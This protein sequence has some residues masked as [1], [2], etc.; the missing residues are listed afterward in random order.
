MSNRATL[1]E[2]TRNG[3]F[4]DLLNGVFAT[5]S[6]LPSEQELARR[7]DVSRLTIREAVG[8]LVEAGYVSRRQGDGTYVSGSL[9]RR[10]ALDTT[11]SYTAMIAAAGMQPGEL[12]LSRVVRPATPEEADRLG[13]DDAEPLVCV[14][15]IRTADKRPVIY[16]VDRIPETLVADAPADGLEASLY[17]LLEQAGHRV[18]SASARL[19]PVVATARLARLLAVR[20]GAPLLHID[21]VDHDGIGRA[22]MLSAEWHV[23]DVFELHINRRQAWPLGHR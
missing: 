5:G 6:K 4:E 1:V 11:V 8:G 3:L 17:A 12:V 2:Q 18:R 22:V 10:H 19:R 16:S 7:F 20:R 23:P 13:T 21:E 9:P 15:R 14:E